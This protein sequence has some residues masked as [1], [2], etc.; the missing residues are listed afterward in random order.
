M[1][2]LKFIDPLCVTLPRD[3]VRADRRVLR[4]TDAST[5][6][7]LSR[8]RNEDGRPRGFLHVAD[9]SLLHCLKH[10]WI[11]FGDGASC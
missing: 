9:R 7:M 4:L 6:A 2:G 1:W 5:R 11:A 3:C 8:V 10:R